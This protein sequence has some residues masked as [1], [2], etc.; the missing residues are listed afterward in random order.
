MAEDLQLLQELLG[1]TC[2]QF[3]P[4][5]PNGRLGLIKYTAFPLPCNY[6]AVRGEDFHWLPEAFES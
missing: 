2:E 4:L 5:A 6:T 1:G 3:C